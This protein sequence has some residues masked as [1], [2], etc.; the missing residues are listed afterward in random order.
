MTGKV[1]MNPSDIFSLSSNEYRCHQYKQTKKKATKSTSLNA[2]SNRVVTNW[3]SL[4]RDVVSAKT[5]NSF[6]NK[7]DDHWKDE[8]FENPFD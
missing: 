8:K 6:K 4:P 3:N 2:F 1:K 7:L 5:T